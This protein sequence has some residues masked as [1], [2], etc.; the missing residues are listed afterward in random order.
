MPTMRTIDFYPAEDTSLHFEPP[1][2]PGESFSFEQDG[3]NIRGR[4][5]VA[6]VAPCV[7]VFTIYAQPEVGFNSGIV[8]HTM[9]TRLLPGSTSI[10]MLRDRALPPTE[11]DM[12]A[13]RNWQRGQE[14]AAATMST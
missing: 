14:P 1:E 2:P 5:T 3:V 10:E 6:E 11:A 4:A 13:Y 12:K 9:V 8:T 7:F